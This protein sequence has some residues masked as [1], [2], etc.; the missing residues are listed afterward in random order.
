MLAPGRLVNGV[1]A[2]RI[3]DRYQP[4]HRKFRVDAPAPGLLWV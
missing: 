1:F 3:D 2:V 4:Q